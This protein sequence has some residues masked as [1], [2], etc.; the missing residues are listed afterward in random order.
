MTTCR[1][2]SGPL[3]AV[4]DDPDLSHPSCAPADPARFAAAAGGVRVYTGAMPALSAMGCVCGL[5]VPVGQRVTLRDTVHGRRWVGDC[6]RGAP[7]TAP[8]RPESDEPALSRL[9]VT[10]AGRSERSG[11]QR[12]RA[13]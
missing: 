13:A 12:R 11:D 5:M 10:P 7:E 6:C 9:P 4:S 2:C 3:T 1:I 8:D